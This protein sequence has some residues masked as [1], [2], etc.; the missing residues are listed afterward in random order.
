MEGLRFR[1]IEG[2]KRDVKCRAKWNF[3]CWK[4][5]GEKRNFV[6]MFIFFFI[7]R[8]ESGNAGGREKGREGKRERG[9]GTNLGGGIELGQGGGKDR[10]R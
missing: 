3:G 5:G 4:G 1:M 6:G 8:E 10:A 7:V 9:K 2:R